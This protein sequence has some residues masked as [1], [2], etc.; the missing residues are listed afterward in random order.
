D[1]ESVLRTFK[2]VYHFLDK[3]LTDDDKEILGFGAIF[4]EHLL[5]KVIRWKNLLLKGGL[6]AI[7]E[8]MLAEA[9][10]D[11][12]ENYPAPLSISCEELYNLI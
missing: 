4:I 6:H 5:C 2:C 9:N 3:Y 10:A 12:A 7:I 8:A 11:E 1:K